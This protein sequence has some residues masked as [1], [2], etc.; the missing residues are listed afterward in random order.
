MSKTAIKTKPTADE[1]AEMA[2][3]GEDVSRFLP[4]KAK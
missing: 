4:T 3:S 2:L 1:L